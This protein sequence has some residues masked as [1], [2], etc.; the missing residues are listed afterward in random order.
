MCAFE[1]MNTKRKRNVTKD[2]RMDPVG[3]RRTMAGLYM[4]YGK[5]RAT[6][7]REGGIKKDDR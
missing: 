7:Q 5:V 3:K 2:R 6:Y 1:K 4:C